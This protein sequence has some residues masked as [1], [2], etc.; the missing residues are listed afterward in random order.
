MS[1]SPSFHKVAFTKTGVE[2]LDLIKSSLL[3]LKISACDLV[4]EKPFSA[5]SIAGWI[6]FL[7]GRE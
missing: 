3:E 7:K 1:V 2:V 4:I 5:R 6:N